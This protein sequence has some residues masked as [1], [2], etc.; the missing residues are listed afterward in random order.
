[1]PRARAIRSR[2]TFSSVSLVVCQSLGFYLSQTNTEAL[3]HRL[4]VDLIDHSDRI[5]FANLERPDF[6][7]TVNQMQTMPG[8]HVNEM[9]TK[10][11]RAVAL[12]ITLS[13]LLVILST[14]VPPLLVYL[15]VLSVPYLVYR[16]WVAKTRY[17]V[18]VGQNR[19]QRWIEYYTRS[20]DSAGN[21]TTSSQSASPNDSHTSAQRTDD[22]SASNYSAHRPSTRWRCS[23]STLRCS[24]RRIA[25]PTDH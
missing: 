1:M 10:C 9:V 18:R 25:P 17:R 20:A 19:S 8:H 15:L 3:E 7:D 16:S 6:Q 11:V 5:D 13:T 21:A 2:R 12:L 4:A 14:I 22:R 23:P 24:A